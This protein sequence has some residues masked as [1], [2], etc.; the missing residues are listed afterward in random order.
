MVSFMT[1]S[2]QETKDSLP[3]QL[4][5]LRFLFTFALETFKKG[6]NMNT[7]SISPELYSHAATYAS[8]HNVSVSALVELSIRRL[9]QS[10]QTASFQPKRMKELSPQVQQLLGAF[11]T[12]EEEKRDLNGSQARMENMLLGYE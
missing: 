5:I 3:N 11:P 9:L 4:I 6:K 12:K 8:S 2:H 1:H 10:E 7:I